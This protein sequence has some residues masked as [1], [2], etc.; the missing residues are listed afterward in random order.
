MLPIL[1]VAL[2][3][4]LL[5]N[6]LESRVPN[7]ASGT[8]VRRLPSGVSVHTEGFTYSQTEG[9]RTRFTVRAKQQVG[10]ENNRYILEDVDVFVFGDTEK[11]PTRTVQGKACTI[12]K[13]TSDFECNGDVEV[14]LD[15]KTIIRTDRL[16]YKH[17][18]RIVIIPQLA[19]LEQ[20][21]TRG[22]ANSVEYSLTTGLMK[23]NGDVNFRTAERTE[24][25][26]ASALVQQKENWVTMSGGVL[27]KSTSGWIRG[28]TGRADLETQTYKPRI[29]TLDGGVTGESKPQQGRDAW[30][31][32][33]SWI[34]AWISPTGVAEQVKTRGNV[35]IEKISG[36]HQRVRGDEVDTTLKDG[37]L[38]SL[39]ARQNASMILGS[40]QTLESSQIW[41]NGSGS[42]RTTG[43]SLLKVGDSTIDGSDF[44][45]ENGDEIVT[46]STMRRATMKK[47]SDQES[48]SDQTR[49]GF[50][51]RTNML[52]SLVQTGR[53][54][55]HDP[56]RQGRAQSAR[57]DNGG[58]IVTLQGS[59]VVTDSQ[60][61]I[62]APEIRLDQEHNSFV[63]TK[64]VTTLMKGEKSEDQT[65]VKSSRAEGG[66]DLVVYMGNVQLWR[67]D[68]YL[69]AHR[70]EAVGQG[71]L[72][73][74]SRIHAE[75]M[76]G[77]RVESFMQNIRALSDTLDYD[78]GRGVIHYI[79]NVQARKQDMIMKAPDMVVTLQDNNVREIVASGGVTVNRADEIGTG[80]RAV[81]DAA[82]DVV[83]L[84]GKNAQ[85]RD[86][87]HGTQQ[88]NIFTMRNKGER[89]TV[90]GGDGE[91]TVTKHPVK[92]AK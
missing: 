90:K 34:Q 61:R 17:N 21:G 50:D 62:E 65:L 2:L 72:R 27:M 7:L 36:D 58:T 70:L 29:I 78:D 66:P 85:L 83:T 19:N 54:E 75:A 24:I 56:E 84:T 42:I 13:D 49:A 1:V 92:P 81:Y 82:T 4:V 25:E 67:G 8:A 11:D 89:V 55:F 69:K 32:S 33:G 28:S 57:F 14:H 18:D 37:R 45:I 87:E 80:E 88:G 46:F 9:G 5:R 91:R 53:F 64:N 16:I 20:E 73:Q 76:P 39:E 22:R 43:K 41:T 10:Y 60:S 59:A 74:G 40:G 47:A 44:V 31:F 26:T 71:Q 30:R 23:L 86:K 51:S 48:S 63:A 38:D 15:E 3:A 6:Y 35:E 79:G 68:S 52:V 77:S 12:D